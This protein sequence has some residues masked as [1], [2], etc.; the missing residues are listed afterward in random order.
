LPY[1]LAPVQRRAPREKE[2]NV[3]SLVGEIRLY[4]SGIECR[5]VALENVSCGCPVLLCHG[6]F[7]SLRGDGSFGGSARD[8]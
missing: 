1:L 8:A 4:V 7:R 6:A 5:D 2:F 3:G